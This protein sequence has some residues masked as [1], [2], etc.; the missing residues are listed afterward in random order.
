MVDREITFCQPNLVIQKHY[1][2]SC[3]V[4]L[5]TLRTIEIRL[6]MNANINLPLHIY[7]NNLNKQDNTNRIF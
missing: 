7:I 4:T 2:L 1:I 5:G 6:E 3:S